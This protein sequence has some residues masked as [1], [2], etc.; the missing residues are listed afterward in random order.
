MGTESRISLI[1]CK[2]GH[3]Q[4]SHYPK[5]VLWNFSNCR[6]WTGREWCMCQGFK[7]DTLKY[8][9]YKYEQSIGK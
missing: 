5:E 1:D 9:E 4:L 2:C 8:L 6:S 3:R 7:L